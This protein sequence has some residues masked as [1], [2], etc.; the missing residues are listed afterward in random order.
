MII[1]F[2]EE[3]KPLTEEE[4]KLLPEFVR[5][6][7]KYTGK[8]NAITNKSIRE[9]YWR[10]GIKLS[11]SRIRKIIN[12]IR[13]HNMVPKLCAN[14]RGYYIAQNNEELQEYVNGLRQRVGAIKAILTTLEEQL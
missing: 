10:K 8:K 1:G 5:C 14:S 3:T 9:G 7:Q 13:L 11:D 12:H 6:L 2:E 4:H